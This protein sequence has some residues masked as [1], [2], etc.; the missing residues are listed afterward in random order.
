MT[1]YR[2][3]ISHD[4]NPM[5]PREDW[6]NV[7]TM[8]CWHRRHS[9]GDMCKKKSDD[10]LDLWHESV[11]ATINAMIS[12]FD[13][14]FEERL[15]QWYNYQYDKRGINKAWCVG[16]AY[17]SAMRDLAL[18]RRTLLWR[19]LKK[20]YV[21]LPLHLYEHSG[22]TMNTSGFSCPWDSGQVG[23]IYVSRKTALKEYGYPELKEPGGWTAAKEQRCVEALQ[24]E[25]EAYDQ[26]LQGDVYG[27]EVEKLVYPFEQPVADE[28]D[29]DDDDLP[30]EP[31][32]S[33]WGFFGDDVEKSG[34]IEHSSNFLLPVFKAAQSDTGEWK[35][36]K[37]E[38]AEE[39]AAT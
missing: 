38:P 13:D 4:D 20:F 22:M 28:V 26:Y 27:F 5:N 32:D 9:L 23:F 12:K 14:V 1:Y 18:E 35:L 30:W 21:V 24:S 8:L 2:V 16:E 31:T 15:S 3:K 33:C 34:M 37:H 17:E 6:D 11:D 36:F 7:G 29:P 39:P 10:K 25:V 19:K